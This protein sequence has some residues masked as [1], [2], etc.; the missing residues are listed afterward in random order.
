M[1]NKELN[2]ILCTIVKEKDSIYK[3]LD[4]QNE[5]DI[6]YGL[7]N[8]PTALLKDKILQVLCNIDI[9][10]LVLDYNFDFF[11][12]LITLDVTAEPQKLIGKIDASFAFEIRS[13][14]LENGVIKAELDFNERIKTKNLKGA[15][16]NSFTKVKSLLA[17]ALE[18]VKL[19]SYVKANVFGSTLKLT[20]NHEMLKTLKDLNLTFIELKKDAMLFSYSIAENLNSQKPVTGGFL[21]DML[22]SS[23]RF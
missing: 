16:L 7:F 1:T 23:D 11:D 15:L 13:L 5:S 14:S 4:N 17:I 9:S 20:I 2:S 18:N 10:K 3:F 6:S 8:I 22:N 21:R 19:P 12:D